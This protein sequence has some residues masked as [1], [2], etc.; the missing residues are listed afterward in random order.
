[1][2]LCIIWAR[3]IFRS[4]AWGCYDGLILQEVWHSCLGLSVF[5]VA[6]SNQYNIKQKVNRKVESFTQEIYI[7]IVNH[8]NIFKIDIK[9]HYQIF[10]AS[11]VLY[12]FF[13]KSA[14]S[15]LVL[16]GHMSII[17]PKVNDILFFTESIT[18]SQSR[19]WR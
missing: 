6:F 7:C 17:E 3:F 18:D 14:L 10:S 1:M 12:I 4:T 11:K 13:F 15:N 9:N 16:F 5:M 8:Q 19:L 2:K